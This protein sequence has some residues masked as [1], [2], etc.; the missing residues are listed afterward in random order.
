MAMVQLAGDP[1]KKHG[2]LE[3]DY[4]STITLNHPIYI[5]QHPSGRDKELAIYNNGNFCKIHNKNWGSCGGRSKT[6]D[7]FYYCDTQGGSSGAPVISR[8]TN[9]V[10]GLH[11]CG[12]KDCSHGNMAVPINKVYQEIE[13]F[14][15]D[16]SALEATEAPTSRPTSFPTSR[17]THS[18]SV[19]PSRSP[20]DVPSR[21]P[22][23]APS[24][25]PSKKPSSLP[26]LMPSQAPSK[27][28]SMS[29]SAMPS[30]YHS[31]TPTTSSIPSDAP[32][33]VPS[34]V[35]SDNPSLS[36]STN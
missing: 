6:S 12:T 1:G 8:F 17:P 14:L 7:F 11:H 9:K 22:S 19:S 20:S 13:S 3:I 35:P 18:P 5:P 16:E 4:Q 21:A 2:Y 27:L 24:R 28:H 31:K 30:L 34:E 15:P 25:I 29:P 10:I 33:L 32:S 26:S 23:R 36:L